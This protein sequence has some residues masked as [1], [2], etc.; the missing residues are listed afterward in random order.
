[1]REKGY[2]RIVLTTSG[3]GLYGNFGQTNYSAAKMGLVGFM[4]TL[5]LEGVKY[6]IKVNT[7]AP[8]AASRLTEDVLPQEMFARMKPDF[9]TGIVLYLSSEKCRETGGIYNAA[10]GYY[11]RAAILTG[12]G[13]ILGGP[14]KIPTVEDIRDRWAEI[15]SLE[16]AGELAEANSAIMSFFAPAAPKPAVV[17]S[18]GGTGAGAGS[19]PSASGTSAGRGGA[20]GAQSGI[21]GALAG[22][23]PV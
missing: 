21:P 22:L 9:V 4:N 2:G 16:G 3:S 13:V 23:M 12:P 1:M 14:E 8:L 20:G 11:S 7:I 5:K 17:A 18:A 19:G 6:N 10:A 15:D